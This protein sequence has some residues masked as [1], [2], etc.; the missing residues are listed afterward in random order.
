MKKP[1][2]SGAILDC[3]YTNIGDFYKEPFIDPPIGLSDHSVVL[4]FP[5]LNSENGTTTTQFHHVRVQDKNS[6]ALF[7]HALSKVNWAKLYHLKTCQEQYDLF[8]D[9]LLQL[10]DTHMPFKTVKRQTNDKPWLTDHF[11]DL[12]K[13]RQVAFH[14][15][16][17]EQFKS[18]RNKVNRERK[19]LQKKHFTK[20]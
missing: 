9:V 1:T 2:R 16:D 7:V 6:K 19:N 3:V 13:Q 11:R 18:L 4:L 8:H 12:M 10:M 20:R 17:M 15:K 14:K 5:K